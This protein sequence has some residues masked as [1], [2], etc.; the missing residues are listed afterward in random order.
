RI[1][2][3]LLLAEAQAAAGDPAGARSA[4]E[5]LAALQRQHHPEQPA[6][7]LQ[8][9]QTLAAIAAAEGRPGDHAAALRAAVAAV[10]RV[11]APKHPR[12]AALRL[13]LAE[14]ELA[15]GNTT[16]AR[17]ELATIAPILRASLLPQA[18]ALTALATLESRL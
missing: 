10:G 14:A 12:A 16:A 1:R 6:L 8:L 15:A 3:G 11:V 9:Q 2:T 18:P 5:P 7:E 13:R 17:R 4:M